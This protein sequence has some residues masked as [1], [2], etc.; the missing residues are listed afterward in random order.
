MAKSNHALITGLFLFSLVILTIIS[1]IWIGRFQKERNQYFVATRASVSGLNPESTVFFRGISVGKVVNIQFD[2]NDSNTILIPIEVD[3]DIVLT[4]AVYAVL[5]L[6]GVTG[7]TQLELQ[8]SGNITQPIPPGDANPKYRIPI[9]PSKTDQLLNAGEEILRKSDHLMVRLNA[10]LSD[11]NEKNINSILT[12]LKS[13]TG[14]LGT[15][16][17]SV[18]SALLEVPGL[19][20][21]AHQTLANMNGL[22]RD[23]RNLTQQVNKLS[24][25]TMDLVDSGVAAGN[26][27]STATLPKF[28]QLL[29]DLQA[30]SGQIK[31]VARF[32]ENDP[33][34]L[35]L[36]PSVPQPPA[37]GEP[38]YQEQP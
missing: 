20:K 24:T 15:L 14:K 38:G 33:Q 31:R 1:I 32:L 28:N 5:Q 18:D 29:T 7:L 11:D 3:K 27:L 9:R 12:D 4:D 26:M 2:P 16:E 23:L 21:N 19:S 22:A 8:D 17:K 37:P 35:L 30:T 36:G 25:K 34:S 10:I 6:K 13:L